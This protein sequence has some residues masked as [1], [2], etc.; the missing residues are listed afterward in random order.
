MTGLAVY[1]Y[2]RVSKNFTNVA[3]QSCRTA[4]GDAPRNFELWSGDHRTISDMTPTSA[5]FHTKGGRLSLDI[6]NEHQSRRVFSG[7]R[8][9]LM[10]RQPRVH[11]LNNYAIAASMKFEEK[12]LS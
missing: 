8:L 12:T 10:K 6:F 4:I 9:E 2:E 7:T 11:D 3:L 5:N 1:G